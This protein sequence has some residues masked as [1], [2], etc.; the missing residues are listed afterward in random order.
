MGSYGYPL[1]FISMIIQ[2]YLCFYLIVW[3]K[4]KMSDDWFLGLVFLLSIGWAFTMERPASTQ[5]TAVNYKLDV[6]ETGILSLRC[7]GKKL[8]VEYTNEGPQGIG[9]TLANRL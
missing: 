4:Q 2:F 7:N 5:S 1:W 6:G 8:P 3:L 9:V